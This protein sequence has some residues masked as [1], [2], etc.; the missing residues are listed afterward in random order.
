M[1]LTVKT[2]NGENKMNY[3]DNSDTT[4][5]FYKYLCT[6]LPVLLDVMYSKYNTNNLT[7]KI[8]LFIASILF[9]IGLHRPERKMRQTFYKK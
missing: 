2:K 1:S 4:P 6:I 9:H 8:N 5:L 3:D 7:T